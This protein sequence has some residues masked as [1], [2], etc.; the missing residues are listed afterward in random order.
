MTQEEATI[1]AEEPSLGA[2]IAAASGKNADFFPDSVPHAPH[3]FSAAQGKAPAFYL[4][5]S[6]FSIAQVNVIVAIAETIVPSLSDQTARRIAKEHMDL[7]NRFNAPNPP[8]EADL[9]LFLRSSSNDMRVAECMVRL[10]ASNVPTDMKDKVSIVLWLLTT[11][12]G[13]SLLTGSKRAAFFDLTIA[14]REKALLG[15]GASKF[16]ALRGLFKSL[17]AVVTLPFF[18]K[19]LAQEGFV[20]GSENP[21]PAWPALQYPGPNPDEHSIPAEDAVWTPTFVDVESLAEKAGKGKPIVL[22]CDVVIVGSGAGG[23]VVA[24]ELSAAG[25]KVIVLEKAIY[26]HHTE[27]TNNE[28]ESF[29]NFYESGA[30][31]ASENSA[32]QI[33]AGTAFGGGTFVNWCASLRT[34]HKVREEWAAKY[35]LPF[36]GGS[37]FQQSL[38]AICERVGVSE[39]GIEHN[40]SNRLFIEGCKK[41]GFDV[42]AIPQNTGG[43]PHNCGWCTF[44]CPYAQKQGSHRTWLQDAAEHGAEF[45]Q[46]CY[47]QKVTQ[48]NGK[49]TGIVGTVLD[50][51]VPI[52]VKAPTVVSS[53][54]SINTPALLLRSGL[55][56]PNIGK[57]LRLHPVTTI[58]GFFPQELVRPFSGAMMTAVS[59]VVADMDGSGYGA[60]LECVATHPG[61]IGSILPWRNAEDYKRIML[62][63]PRSVNLIVLT[64]DNDSKGSIWI[65]AKG[66]PRVEFELGKKDAAA[67]TAGLE[68]GAKL[69][70]AV[71]AVEINT[72]QVGNLPLK[73]VEEADRADPL[74]SKPFKEWTERTKKIGVKM[75][76]AGISCAHQMGSCRMASTPKLG[77]VN[78]DGESWE[79]K[80]LYVADASLFPT[81]SG[82]NPMVTTFA[83]SHAVA[84]FMKRNLEAKKNR[85][86]A[87]I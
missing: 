59:N 34:P 69:L 39:D 86:K 36:F 12:W 37:G 48:S 5:K 71:G 20:E 65:D 60:R 63:F 85:G 9:A 80:G 38:D 16:E 43:K 49:A 29:N 31:M 61:I 70:S 52:I 18:G 68:A 1:I 3:K 81:A 51:S 74:N 8:N 64:R 24:A 19:S 83:V 28:L 75:N 23:G 17:K 79:V 73:L 58:H 32:M 42:S 57:N 27:L 72:S 2:T 25:H 84:Q 87:K 7:L 15:L 4:E 53:C 50:G 40:T 41:V 47:V 82:V 56:N 55:R 77:A 14:E 35:G 67:M 6:G 62:Q 21:N 46:G 54:G 30:A 66:N 76:S 44:G 13:T 11:P 10:L 22:E 26:R 78:P 45:I 33:L